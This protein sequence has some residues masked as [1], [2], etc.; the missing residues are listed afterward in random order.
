MNSD[1]SD[2]NYVYP[3]GWAQNFLAVTSEPGTT[4]TVSKEHSKVY[5]YMGGETV[6]NFELDDGYGEYTVTAT[7]DG[8]SNSKI[9]NNTFV[10]LHELTILSGLRILEITSWNK[11]KEISN[12]GTAANY[13]SIGDK[14][15]VKINGTI[16]GYSYDTTLYVYIIDFEHNTDVEGTG[17][18]FMGFKDADGKGISLCAP[19]F[20]TDNQKG[21]TMNETNIV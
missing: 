13:W 6:H 3:K 17:I 5:T 7:E 15:S 18:C 12:A 20:G 4:V 10:G 14:K 21:F 9:F 16:N 8:F 11:I 1:S 19:N 2:Y